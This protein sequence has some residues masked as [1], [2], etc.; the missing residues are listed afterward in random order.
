MEYSNYQKNIF[1]WVKNRSGN[2]VVEAIAGS[3]KTFVL[4]EALN[5][6]PPEASVLLVAF[7]VSI[8]KELKSRI[9]RFNTNI[10]TSHS[11]GLSMIYGRGR[12]EIDNYKYKTYLNLNFK[13]L[14]HSCD[15]D[16]KEFERVKKNVLDLVNLC[17]LNLCRTKKEI[18]AIADKYGYKIGDCEGLLLQKLI[19]WGI[20]NDNSVDYTDMLSLPEYLNIPSQS[21]YD[22]IMCDEVQDFSVA[23]QKLIKRCSNENTRFFLCGDPKQCIQTFAGS[24][25]DSFKNLLLMPDTVKLPLSINYRCPKVIEKHARRFVPQFEVKSDAIPGVINYDV[26]IASIKDKSMVICR[27]TAPLIKLYIRLIMEG[28]KCFIKGLEF[29]DEL[30]RLINN[31]STPHISV[32]LNREGL[33]PMLYRNVFQLR[34]GLIRRYNLDV[35]DAITETNIKRQLEIIDTI[36]ILSFGI[37]STYDLVKR[38]KTIFD[39]WDNGG[40]CL[41]TAHKAKGLENEYVY[42]LCPSLLPSKYAVK[43]WEVDAERNLEYVTITRT[44][45]ELNYICEKDFPVPH[46]NGDVEALIAR[47]S[48]IEEKIKN[49]GSQPINTKGGSIVGKI[50]STAPKHKSTKKPKKNGKNNFNISKFEKLMLGKTVD[51]CYDIFNDRG[52]TETINVIE[53]DDKPSPDKINVKLTDNKIIAILSK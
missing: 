52:I 10:R 34:D 27:N 46:E 16:K 17:R 37:D 41:I 7:N 49:I 26:K 20:T 44:K 32:D 11:L 2:A 30:V 33:I 43:D 23:Q 3:G 1:E 50:K 9:K 24:D 31:Y 48:G 51:Q 8:V 6:I 19:N 22:W 53:N 36:K 25:E 47:L 40:I 15:L 38:I 12:P 35:K 21:T 29:Q 18:A 5:F 14:A 4:K 13:S 39:T 42:I 45:N 28:R